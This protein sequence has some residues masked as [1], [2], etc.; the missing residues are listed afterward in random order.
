MSN[1]APAC[2]DEPDASGSTPKL[3]L[4]KQENY[5]PDE[6]VEPVDIEG[7]QRSEGGAGDEGGGGNEGTASD[8]E[9][10]GAGG[11]DLPATVAA[12]EAPW[13]PNPPPPPVRTCR[14]PTEPAYP[15]PH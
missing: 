6:T 15:P 3:G 11:G 5:D 2:K 14:V 7:G 4:V 13:K 8:G 1:T 10:N 12:P 9:G